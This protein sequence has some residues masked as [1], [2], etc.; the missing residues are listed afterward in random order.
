MGL[1]AEMKHHLSWLMIPF[2]IIISWIFLTM[3][4]VG[5]SSED[6]FEN[7]INDVPMNAICR[8]IE[9]DLLQMLGETDLPEKVQPVDGVLM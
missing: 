4:Q 2:Y 8:T 6:P 5:D 9:I 7:F 1:F 3:E